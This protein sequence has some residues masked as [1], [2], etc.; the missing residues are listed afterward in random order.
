VDPAGTDLHITP[1][2]GLHI[3]LYADTPVVDALAGT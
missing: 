3:K 1:Y 2:A